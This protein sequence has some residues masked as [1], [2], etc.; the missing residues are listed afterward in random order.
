MLTKTTKADFPEDL[1][2]ML[3]RGEITLAQVFGLDDDSLYEIARV[4][5]GLLNSGKLREAK[6]IYAGL[7][8]AD[9]YDSVFHCHLAVVHHSLGELDDAVTHYTQALNLNR[10]NAD[11]LV[12][13]GEIQLSRGELEAGASALQQAIDLD[14]DGAK[15][16]T[17]RARALL[18]ANA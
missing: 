13:L 18:R 15:P 9:P 6:Q 3:I 2:V 8:A 1:P 5:Y 11:A 10:A 16:S 4:G 14:G 7:V 17:Q 12:G